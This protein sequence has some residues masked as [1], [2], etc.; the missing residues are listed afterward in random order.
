MK[1]LLDRVAIEVSAT[2]NIDGCKRTQRLASCDVPDDVVL[3]ILF[4]RKRW[5]RVVLID[6]ERAMRPG[7]EILF[8]RG[9]VDQVDTGMREPLLPAPRLASPQLDTLG[10]HRGKIC[11]LRRPLDKRLG[12]VLAVDDG[13]GLVLFLVPEDADLLA[14]VHGNLVAALGVA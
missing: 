7:G 6:L 13:V 9:I 5:N 14:A 8:A 11:A 10:V 1:L 3:A 4:Q 12:P 2:W